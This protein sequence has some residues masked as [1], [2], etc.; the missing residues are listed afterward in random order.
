MYLGAALQPA[1]S[2]EASG[3]KEK[4]KDIEKTRETTK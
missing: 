2:E 3:K 4:K 1:Q